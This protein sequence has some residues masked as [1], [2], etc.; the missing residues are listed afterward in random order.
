M[1]RKI[2]IGD[3][4]DYYQLG[5]ELN[6]EFNKLFNLP[7]LLN[8]EYNYIYVYE[9]NKKILG[10][11]HIQKSFDE[12]DIINIVVGPN[13]RKRN[14]GKSLINYAIRIN[15]LSIL[16]I[17]VRTHNPAVD[18]YKILGFK[19]YRTIKKYYPN[20]DAYFMKKEV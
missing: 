15:S 8:K 9:D 3:E 2:D 19:I 11:I 12:A 7:E 20:D 5:L 1:I 10:F 13:Y 17:E 16:N 18:F 6:S 4:E 14:I